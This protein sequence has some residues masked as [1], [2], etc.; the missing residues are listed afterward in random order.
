[1]LGEG[2]IEPVTEAAEWI[3]PLLVVP[4]GKDD[5]RICVNMKRP[6]EAIRRIEH[7]LPIFEDYAPRLDNAKLFSRLDIKSAYLHLELDE[8]SRKMTTFFTKKGLFR[9]TRLMFGANCAPEVFQKFMEEVLAG[10]DGV[11]VMIDDIIVHGKTETEHDSRLEM[12]RQRLGKYNLTVNE[13]KSLFKVKELDFLGFRITSNGWRPTTERVKALRE[14]RRPETSEEISS[15]LGLVSYVGSFIDH[16]ADKRARLQVAAKQPFQW[17]K[18]LQSD[19]D[20]LRRALETET[21]TKAY[22]RRNAKTYLYTDASGIGLGAVLIQKHKE[23]QSDGSHV[24][25]PRIIAFASKTLSDVEK[26]YAQTHR[27]A[28]AVVWG[29]ERFFMYLFGTEFVIM[30]DHAPLKFIFGPRPRLLTKRMI[31]RAEAWALRLQ[32]YRYTLQ[33]VPGKQNIADVLSRLVRPTQSAEE[34]EEESPCFLAAIEGQDTGRVVSLESIRRATD[35]DDEMR[36]VT[37]ALQS[38]E[39]QEDLQKYHVVADELNVE[40]GLIVRDSRVVI[41]KKLRGEVMQIAHQGHPGAVTMKHILRDRV[42]WPEMYRQIDAFYLLCPGCAAVQRD[43]PP[44]GLSPSVLP[45]KAWQDVAIDFLDIP[46]YKVKILVIVD[47]YSRHVSVELMTRTDAV[48]LIQKLQGIFDIWGYPDSIRSDNGPPFNS[49]EFAKWCDI[50][51]IRHDR[52]TPYTPQQNGEVERQNR[53][54]VRALIIAKATN[55]QWKDSLA[56]YIRSYN[57]RPHRTTGVAP[58]TIMLG[59][60]AKDELPQKIGPQVARQDEWK[61]RDAVGKLKS[62]LYTDDRR[63]A[64]PC[65]IQVGDE[66]IVKNQVPGKLQPNYLIDDEV[67]RVV[68]ARVGNEFLVQRGVDGPTTR[69]STQQV[70]KKFWKSVP[71]ELDVGEQISAPV[72]GTVLEPRGTVVSREERP[73]RKPSTGQKPSR[74][75]TEEELRQRK[76]DENERKAEAREDAIEAITEMMEEMILRKTFN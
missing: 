73:G 56:Q 60:E 15:F 47:Y 28:L 48:H 34:F 62:K 59:R 32:P 18:Q 25:V 37:A 58:L 68:T 1:M 64:K 74:Y 20:D 49:G 11:M 50:K 4:K 38:G 54:I 14:F 43:N 10:V 31:T 65:D 70:K 53:G 23:Q 3:S 67:P 12:V 40:Q 51:D 75:M 39:W 21:L 71:T 19:F 17:S 69:H 30:T 7:P 8:E 13:K 45:E 9:Y 42:W 52:T 76:N 24:M 57:R 36:R 72:R 16:L 26:R 61:Q 46:E 41:P 63:H 33:Y 55:E 22:F 44:E 29:I 6:N 66:V 2:I 5:I 27:E 35:M